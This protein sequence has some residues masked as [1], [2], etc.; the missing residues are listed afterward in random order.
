MAIF[1]NVVISNYYATIINS[2]IKYSGRLTE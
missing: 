2:G 1:L